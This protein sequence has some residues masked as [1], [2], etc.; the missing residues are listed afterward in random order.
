[1]L[2]ATA[3]C[4]S[5]RTSRR[6]LDDGDRYQTVYAAEPGFRRRADGRPALHPR[7]A[8]SR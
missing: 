2:T 8:R 3:R 1:M 4:R 7:A 6:R 5:R